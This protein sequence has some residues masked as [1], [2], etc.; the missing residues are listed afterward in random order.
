MKHAAVRLPVFLLLD[1]RTVWRESTPLQRT[2]RFALYVLT[3]HNFVALCSAR[4]YPAWRRPLL[5]QA[6]WQL[7]ADLASCF[8][9]AALLASTVREE[10][11]A[12]AIGPL[13]IGYSISFLNGLICVD[14][15]FL[16]VNFG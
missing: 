5:G 3:P 6:G 15:F 16:D 9:L 11:N 2:M 4:C 7:L 13:K 10:H 8:A 1:L 12:G 14:N